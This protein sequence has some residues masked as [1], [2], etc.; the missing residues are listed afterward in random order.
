MAAE[1]GAGQ[2]LPV[3]RNGAPVG[4]QGQ[5][6]PA[7]RLSLHPMWPPQSDLVLRHT[8]LFTCWSFSLSFTVPSL[9]EA[10]PGPQPPEPPRLSCRRIPPSQSR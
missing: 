6:G 8:Y 4:S 2:V 3:R 7:R 5:L 10:V 1:G 9:T